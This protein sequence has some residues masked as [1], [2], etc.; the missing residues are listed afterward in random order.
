MLALVDRPIDA[1][2]DGALAVVQMMRGII[3]KPTTMLS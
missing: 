3:T 1:V 2:E